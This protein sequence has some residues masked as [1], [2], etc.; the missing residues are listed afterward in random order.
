MSKDWRERIKVG[1][2]MARLNRHVIGECEMTTTQIAA[3]KLLLSKVA[4][5][6]R[7]I[8]HTGVIDHRATAELTNV[9]L[10]ERIAELSPGNAS[11]KGSSSKSTLVH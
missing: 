5:D 3:A 8:E 1:E 2:I 6:L 9:E 7:A 10:A 4:P 11:Q